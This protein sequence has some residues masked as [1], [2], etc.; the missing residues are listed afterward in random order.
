MQRKETKLTIFNK[1]ILA[2]VGILLIILSSVA[3]VWHGN[4]NS[5]QAVPAMLAQVYFEGEYRIGDGE[6]ITIRRAKEQILLATPHN[7]SFYE[8]LHC[9]MMWDVDIRN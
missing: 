1:R 5:T 6:K 9:K 8:T 2:I 4:K 7:I 3:L